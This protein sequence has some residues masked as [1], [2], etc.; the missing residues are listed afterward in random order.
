MSIR[1]GASDAHWD[2]L[3]DL[4]SR[5]LELPPEQ[6]TDFITCECPD[7]PELAAEVIGLLACDDGSGSGTSPLTNAMKRVIDDASHERRLALIGRMVAAYRIT[8]LIGYGGVGT[9]YLGE[10]A[11]ERYSAKVAIK[12]VDSAALHPDLGLRFRA[13]R[14]ILA[15]LDHPNIARLIDAGETEDAHPYL[16]MEYVEGRTVDVYCDQQQLSIDERLH[17][18]MRLCAAVHY[19]HQHL[20]IHRDLKPANVVVSAD[21]LPKLLDFGIAKLLATD[22]TA[23]AGVALTRVND[24]LLTPRYAS[25]EQILGLPV[26]TATDVYSLGTLLYELLTGMHPFSHFPSPSN[27]ELERLI[28]RSDP[29]SPSVAVQ[30]IIET[31]AGGSHQN[32]ARLAAARQLGA[33]RLAHRLTGDLDAICMQALRKEP[34]HR[35]ASAEQLANDIRRHLAHRPV[36]ARQRTWL[37]R[38]ECFVR[39]HVLGVAA[40]VVSLAILLA[41]A[42]ATSVQAERI[43]IE[44]D[45]AAQEQSRAE[46][47]STFMLDVFGTTDRGTAHEKEVTARELLDEAARRIDRDLAQQPEVQVRLLEAMGLSYRRQGYYAPAVVYLDRALQLRRRLP[48]TD[49]VVLAGTLLELAIARRETGE[50][51]SARTDLL[52][53][54]DLLKTANQRAHALRA[55]V[56]AAL[57]RVE[58]ERSEQRSAENYLAESVRLMRAGNPPVFELVDVLRDLGAAQ[59]WDG[60]SVAGEKTLREA[61]AVSRAHL[62]PLHPSRIAA[63]FELGEF[64]SRRRSDADAE[65]I[66]ILTSVLQARRTL[67]GSTHSEIAHTLSALAEIHSRRGQGRQAEQ[68]MREVLA[69]QLQELGPDH[70]LVG[71]E[72]T[73]LGVVLLARGKNAEAER[74]MRTSL[75][76]Y[77]RSLPADHQYV[78]TTEHVLG[79]A[80]IAQGRYAEAE[81]VLIGARDRW[82]RANAAHWRIARTESALGEAAYRQHRLAEGERLLLTGYRGVLADTSAPYRA[83]QHSYERLVRFYRET[84]QAQRLARIVDPD[85]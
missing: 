3:Q 5:A 27:L 31:S 24:R 62:S 26:T 45:R 53:A 36:I 75:S 46:A 68:L 38:S 42:V 33:Q 19:A 10:R 15:N 70:Y 17:L 73:S 64:L 18:F 77:A 20:V 12:V 80:L 61:V 51:D 34:Q 60:D 55:R 13:E 22:D 50:L 35:Y 9:V 44:R 67:Y 6:R 16:V 21:G 32:L 66:A 4:F 82:V 14:Q 69:I 71:Y 59:W 39:R 57:G 37:Y 8:G 1:G 65:S 58:L 41:F 49:D 54:A 43:A 47:I 25:P 29:Q 74:E 63:E 7:E 78:A 28:S 52:V 83:R 72:H 23:P 40:A 76:I 56:L 11:D 48:G 85:T 79:E 30:T 2:R 81:R 84:G